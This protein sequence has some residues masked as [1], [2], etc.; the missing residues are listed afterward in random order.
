MG[1]LSVLMLVGCTSQNSPSAVVKEYFEACKIGDIDKAVSFID[2]DGKEAE[3]T[4]ERLR[5]ALHPDNPEYNLIRNG[6]GEIIDEQI[7]GDYAEVEY[8][9]RC[10]GMEPMHE[11]GKLVKVFDKW[12]LDD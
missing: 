3:R 1:I 11:T 12:M 10:N 9:I 6:E 8:I 2:I 4:K 7:D 5:K